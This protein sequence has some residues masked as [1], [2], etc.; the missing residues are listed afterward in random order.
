LDGT[1]IS[2]EDLMDIAVEEGAD[3]L[4]LQAQ[5]FYLD[6]VEYRGNLLEVTEEKRVK[7]WNEGKLGRDLRTPLNTPGY[8]YPT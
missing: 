2:T 1:L 3:R 7:L 6:P 5:R 4:T 8:E